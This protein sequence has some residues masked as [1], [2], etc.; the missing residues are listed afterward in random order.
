MTARTYATSLSLSIVTRSTCDAVWLGD[1]AFLPLL[2]TIDDQSHAVGQRSP[3]STW[4]LGVDVFT[5]LVYHLTWMNT[6]LSKFWQPKGRGYLRSPDPCPPSPILLSER[7]FRRN[8]SHPRL[9]PDW[10]ILL[11]FNCSTRILV[12]SVAMVLTPQPPSG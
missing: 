7:W 3:P 4:G 8:G 2:P 11:D 10:A 1:D 12:S 6:Q 9:A 5:I